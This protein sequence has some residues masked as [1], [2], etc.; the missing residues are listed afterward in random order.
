[1][2]KT[3]LTQKRKSL[4]FNQIISSILNIILFPIW[5]IEALYIL[6]TIPRV[7]GPKDAT[8]GIIENKNAKESVRVLIIGESTVSGDGLKSFK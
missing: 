6:K 3:T 1:M 4:A 2:S 5:I 8:E 7:P